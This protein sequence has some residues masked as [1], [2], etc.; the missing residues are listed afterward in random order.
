M[1]GRGTS[2]GEQL[3]FGSFRGCCLV[4]RAAARCC[5]LGSADE[6]SEP[7]SRAVDFHA[8]ALFGSA[9]LGEIAAAQRELQA[10]QNVS[11]SEEPPDEARVLRLPVKKSGARAIRV[12]A[13]GQRSRRSARL[14]HGR[15]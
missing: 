3:L 6:L 2:L 1:A 15:A 14:S 10:W 9:P 7:Q 8:L 4:M 13:G 11:R 12:A 5:G